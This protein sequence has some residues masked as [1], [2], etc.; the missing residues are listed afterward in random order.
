MKN[1][2]FGL[3]FLCVASMGHANPGLA[4]PTNGHCQSADPAACGWGSSSGSRAP[5]FWYYALAY[6][7]DTG[8]WQSQWGN[9]QKMTLAYAQKYCRRRNVKDETSIFGRGKP[10]E[11]SVT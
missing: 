2:I 10:C 9:R 4:N 11:Q 3:A 6:D 8:A 1:A 5:E 7:E